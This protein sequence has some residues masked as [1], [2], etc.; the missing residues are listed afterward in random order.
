MKK[1]LFFIWLMLLSLLFSINIEAQMTIGGKKAPEPYSVLELTSIGGLRLPQMTTTQ[2]NALGVTGLDA[3]SH[4]LVIYNTTTTCIEYWD[5]VRWVS[6]CDG[7]SQTVVNPAPCTDIL[8]DGTGCTSTFTATDIDCPNGPYDIAIVSGADYASLSNVDNANGSFQILFNEN[9]SVN[10]HSVLVRVTTSCAGMYKEFLFSQKGVDCSSMTYTPPIISQ[11]PAQLGLCQSGAVYLSVPSNTTNLD[12]LIWTRN[13]VEIAR[14]VSHVTAALR[15]KYNVSMGAIGCNVNASNE[16]I[17]ADVP[18]P[19][20]SNMTVFASNNGVLCG[21]N[22]VTLSASGAGS[23]TVI[24]FHDGKEDGRTGINLVLTGDSS[25]GEWFAALK[26][27]SCYSLPTNSTTVTKS[28]ATG[29]V[30]INPADVLVNGLALSTFNTFCMGGSLDLSVANKQPGISYKWYNGNDIIVSN[31]FVIP[32]GQTTLSLRMVATDDSGVNCPAEANILNKTITSDTAPAQP[33]ITGSS[34]LCDGTTDLTIVPAVAGTYTYT[35]YKDNVKMADTT[36][37]ITINSPGVVYNATVTNAT[38]CVS[39]MAVKVIAANV[40]SIPKL[41]WQSQVATATYGAKVSVQTAIEFGPAITYTWTADNGATIIG[42]GSSVTIQF[43]ASGTDGTKVNISVIAENSCGKSEVLP[44]VITM[45]NA[46]PTPVISAQSDLV[47]NVNSGS[48]VTFK[49]GAT[50]FIN[51]T[52]QWYSNTTASTVGGNLIAGATSASYTASPTIVSTYYLYCMVTNGC[53]GA[54]IPSP[55]FTINVNTN[56]DN[57]PIGTGSFGGR[58][59]FD[60]AESNDGG[61]CGQLSSRLSG[62]ANF[63]LASVNTQTYTFTPS[64]VV[65][66]VRFSYKE[67]LGGVV[68]KSIASSTAENTLN[69]N[70]PVTATVV[71]NSTLSTGISGQ[72]SAY[73]RMSANALTVDLY[74]VYNN[75]ADGTGADVQVKLS[76]SI[77]DCSCCGAMISPTV[78][79]AF[80]CYNLGADESVSA[81][82]PSEKLV[83]AWYQWGKKS[84]YPA[85]SWD[86]GSS[87]LRAI[88]SWGNNTG[89]K[90]PNAPC[91]AGFRVPTQAEWQGVAAN[92]TKT[93]MGNATIKANNKWDAGILI[94]TSLFLPYSGYIDRSGPTNIYTNFGVWTHSSSVR[95]TENDTVYTFY[96]S[97][98]TGT[99]MTTTGSY[100]N[101]GAQVRCMSEQ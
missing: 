101:I 28:A 59:C 24:W 96:N 17:I 12:K 64:G 86:A 75:K 42:T 21:A 72:G 8:A 67:S 1:N 92:N 60:V 37:T 31:P 61:A 38:G 83:G 19:I 35:W 73:G 14:G 57:L 13:G 54:A 45:N 62:Q 36:P 32:T 6:L 46:C 2:R 58:S 63:N 80:M 10:A 5:S 97:A 85:A 9:T 70:T 29:Q 76:I 11:S 100:A 52:F 98:G 33:N 27:G 51:P 47:Q 22:S 30:T 40:S 79:K 99:Y 34:I 74:V 48:T 90:G 95:G 20:A 4:G 87:N 82:I 44:L 94:G 71:Y 56:P 69:V 78:W 88:T 49:I 15:G 3:K 18:T 91:P 39:A 81:I 43:P 89:V 23:A 68:I 53:N 65:S 50:G 26:D 16:R 25:A 77:K 41:S 66:K 55:V 93:F 7:T 84:P